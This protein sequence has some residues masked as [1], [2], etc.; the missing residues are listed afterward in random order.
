MTAIR[1]L[2]QLDDAQARVTLA[3]LLKDRG[4]LIRAEAVSAIALRGSRAVVLGAAADPSWRVRLK[5]AE[6]LAGYGDREGA[7]RRPTPAGRPQR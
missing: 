4:E 6:A 2:G 5:V 3:G 7:G 1:G